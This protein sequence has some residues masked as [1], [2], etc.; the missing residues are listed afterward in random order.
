[1]GHTENLRKEERLLDT[2]KNDYLEGQNQRVNQI[3]IIIRNFN[4]RVKDL[5]QKLKHFKKGK[6][7]KKKG[8]CLKEH[9]LTLLGNIRVA[10]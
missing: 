6:C 5:R 1:M 7:K 10:R 2:K 4:L 8:K 9:G 3:K